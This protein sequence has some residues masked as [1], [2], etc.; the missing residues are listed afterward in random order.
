[1]VGDRLVSEVD[2]RAHHTGEVAYEKDRRRDRLLVE[3][4]YIVI[5]LTYH[6]ITTEWDQAL[7]SI[8]AVIRRRDHLGRLGWRP[9]KAA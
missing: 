4:N 2:I 9:E 3:R 8:L 5:R 1:M 6:Q 7:A